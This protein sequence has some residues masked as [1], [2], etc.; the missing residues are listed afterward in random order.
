MGKIPW[1]VAAPAIL[2]SIACAGLALWLIA[3]QD[4]K[5][6]DNDE[7]RP[8]IAPSRVS[9][10]EGREILVLDQDA[11][12]KAGLV[13]AMPV[14]ARLSRT[15]ASFGTVVEPAE[16]VEAGAAFGEAR[17]RLSAAEARLAAAS[18]ALARAKALFE[19]GKSLSLAQLQAAEEAYAAEL[20]ARGAAAAQLRAVD[21]SAR[22]RWGDL[23]ARNIAE[24]S[25]QARA[26]REGRTLLVRV[27]IPGAEP[28]PATSLLSWQGSGAIEA[29]LVAALPKI[30][31]RFQQRLALYSVSAAQPLV[32]G[33]T[34]AVSLP[35]GAAREGALIP[36]GAVV[37][38]EGGAWVYR[39][40][41]PGRFGRDRVSEP[42]GQ[43][44]D[45]VFVPSLP[46]DRKV[47]VKGAQTLL[48]EEAREHIQVGEEGRSK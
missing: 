39:E 17:P 14:A 46:A 3:A 8:I 9:R 33:A 21:D 31:P 12:E 32:P 5:G 42:E 45:A 25:S 40:L 35:R 2:L 16:I 23:L 18:A 47:V 38:A 19:D 30:D 36:A 48:S 13:T 27:A 7:D 43:P 44:D 1:R 10:Q 26:L 41:S 20:A 24:D 34:V 37:W 11:Q 6:R 4:D 22:Q 28:P 15:V 29:S